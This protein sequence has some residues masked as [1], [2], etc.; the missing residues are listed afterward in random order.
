MERTLINCKRLKEILL[1]PSSDRNSTEEAELV[2]LLDRLEPFKSLSE[3]YKSNYISKYSSSFIRLLDFDKNSVIYTLNDTPDCIFIILQ[4]SVILHYVNKGLKFP[5]DLKTPEIYD[6]G[7][8]VYDEGENSKLNLVNASKYPKKI[9]NISETFGKDEVF[10]VNYV[11]HIACSNEHTVTAVVDKKILKNAISKLKEQNSA[12]IKGFLYNLNLFSSWSK[13]SISRVSGLFVLEVISK[14]QYIYRQGDIPEYAYFIKKGEFTILQYIKTS[15]RAFESFKDNNA[16]SRNRSMSRSIQLR[17]VPIALKGPNELL[18]VEEII[19]NAETREY[20]CMCCTDS[21]EVLKIA[22][23]SFLHKILHPDVLASFKTSIKKNQQWL[24]TRITALEKLER[25][26]NS[27]DFAEYIKK[28]PTKKKKESFDPILKLKSKL[29]SKTRIPSSLNYPSSPQNIRTVSTSSATKRKLP[30]D[31]SNVKKTPI[32]DRFIYKKSPPSS[33]LISFRE[34]KQNK[35]VFN[36]Q[37]NEVLYT[38]P[39]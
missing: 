31:S 16:Q 4:G 1:I 38:L 20:S 6:A 22:K 25:A 10:K 29:N 33:F 32:R 8:L 36:K 19:E 30:V 3:K 28:P 7:S 12:E 14:N 37:E 26:K 24:N 13:S 17:K 39:Y 21:A 27:L 9:L 2:D 23:E 5:S 34:K 15:P 35:R 11:D 18:G